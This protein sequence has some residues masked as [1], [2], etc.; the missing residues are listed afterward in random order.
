MP[1]R[2]RAIGVPA[3]KT[4]A[5]AALGRFAKDAE[6]SAQASIQADR[7]ALTKRKAKMMC[8]SPSTRLGRPTTT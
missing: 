2:N 5:I 6:V 7:A 8:R 1:P 3:S 4:A